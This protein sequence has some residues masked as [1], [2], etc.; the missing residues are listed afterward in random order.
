MN[1]RAILAAIACTL[2]TD[3]VYQALRIHKNTKPEACV[4]AILAF[5]D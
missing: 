5:H 2:Y 1:K 3:F 4:D